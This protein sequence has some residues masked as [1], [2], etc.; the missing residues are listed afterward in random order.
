MSKIIA[1]AA[2]SG[3]HKLVDRDYHD[4]TPVGMTFS[5]LAELVGGGQQTPG[6]IGIGTLYIISKKFISAEG[7]LKRLVWLTTNIKNKIRD[8]LEQRCREE[9]VPDL[10]DKIADETI[11]TDIE[12]LA[13]WLIE[14]GHP[15][16][17][18]GEMM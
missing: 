5:S 14:K 4:M 8:S 17:E 3:A 6:F 12:E 1:S 18:M 11:T 13:K 7:G 2:I 10:P 9:G 16:L 15:A